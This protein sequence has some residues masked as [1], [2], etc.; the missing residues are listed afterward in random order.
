MGIDTE[1][2]LFA[3]FGGQGMML[4]GKLLAEAMMREGRHVTFFPSYGSEVRG[5]TAHCHVIF[6]REEISSPVVESAD[7][8]IAMNQPSYEKF[9]GRTRRGGLFLVNTSLARA[10]SPPERVRIVRVPAT[11]I[12]NELGNVLTANMV[13]LGVYLGIRRCL[14]PEHMVDLL[15]ETLTGR[16][17]SL[18]DINCRAL[19]RGLQIARC[20]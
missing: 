12:A 2:A 8:V 14:P 5:G 10:T 20:K 18:F 17:A 3:G 11:Q 19:E 16:K 1:K 7:T 4:L 13:M 9:K 15:R 6:S